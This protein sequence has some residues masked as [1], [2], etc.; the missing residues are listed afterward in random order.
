MLK[1]VF[2][3]FQIA[4]KLSTSGAIDTINQVHQIPIS[5]NLFFSLISIGSKNTRLQNK[6]PGKN[7]CEALQGM[8]TTFIKLGQFLATRPDIIGEE[9]AKDLERLQDK[10]PAFELYEAKKVI[11]KEIGEK[12]YHNIIE[13]GEPV[14][15]ASIAQVHFAKIK[16]ENEEKEVAIKI[17]RPDIEKLFNEELDALMLFAYIVENTIS[18]A[19]RLKLVEVVHLLREITNIEM[20][21]R[22]EAA[23]ANE[24]YENTKLDKGFKVPKIYWNYTTKKILTLDKV[25]GVSIRE[26][27]K[28][29][30][31]GINLK[32]L[33][34][35]LIQHFLKQAVRDGFFHGD[36]HQGNLFVDPKGNIV[37]VDFGIMGRLDKNNRK[38][39]AEILYGFIQRDYVKVAEV[40]FQAG[41]GPQNTSKDEFAQALR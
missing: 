8:G 29:E 11:K 37:P 16:N 24:L 34:E 21:L 28:L 19:K 5:I 7:L 15:A 22:F 20:D 39:L 35:N 30:E 4:R 1:R 31:Q 6:N 27:E 2:K 18:K 13:I 25:N 12:Q 10:V 9:M 32:N 41:L 33:A 3:L 23:A 17:L 40:H 38:F 14:A 26:Q 36:M